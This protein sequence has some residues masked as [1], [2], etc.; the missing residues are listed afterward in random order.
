MIIKN[1]S[2]ENFRCFEKIELIFNDSVNL[3]TG[4][5]GCGKTSILESLQIIS[6][7][8]S[9]RSSRTVNIRKDLC[10]YFLI[11]SC[12]QD[13]SGYFNIGL[14]RNHKDVTLRINGKNAERFSEATRKLSILSFNSDTFNLIDGES[15]YRRRF[16]D[17]WLFYAHDNFHH[18]WLNYQRILKQRNSCLRND[19]DMLDYWDY[20]LSQSGELI[21]NYREYAF[22]LIYQEFNYIDKIFYKNNNFSWSYFSGW[23]KEKSLL[24]ALTQNRQKD[25]YY[26]YTSVGPHRADIRI[27][28]KN[29]NVKEILSRGQKKKLILLM[30][31]ALATSYKNFLHE[32]PIFMLDDF[33]SELNSSHRQIILEKILSLGGQVFFTALEQ[34]ELD[35]SGIGSLSTFVLKDG[36]VSMV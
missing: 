5:N 1:L 26:G 25:I 32:S 2:L 20:S 19:V 18:E 22:N 3:I 15:S 16:I 27:L 17:W 33:P 35:F 8:K 24:D 36:H 14:Q 12:I 34:T 10:D 7:G 23:S 31:S 28:T 13:K 29:K 6:T 11:S 4:E 21:N 9:F 30:L